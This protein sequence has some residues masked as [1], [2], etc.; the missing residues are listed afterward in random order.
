MFIHV[1]VQHKIKKVMWM[2][3]L[4]HRGSLAQFS[5][6][7]VHVVMWEICRDAYL[8]TG[9]AHPIETIQPQELSILPRKFYNQCKKGRWRK[10]PT[11]QPYLHVVFSRSPSWRTLLPSGLI[12]SCLHAQLQI[13]CNN[14]SENVCHM[15]AS[16]SI[17]LTRSCPKNL[18]EKNSLEWYL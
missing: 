3:S 16:S 8:K 1:Y 11:R 7:V 5:P 13:W 6:H 10:L 2:N 9:N 15:P 18:S 14:R 17:W 4:L 12:W